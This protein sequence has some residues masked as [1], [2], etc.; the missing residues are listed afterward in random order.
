MSK[1]KN[2]GHL[3]L[4][5]PLVA[6]LAGHQDNERIT[7]RELK[8]RGQL[9]LLPL[10]ALFNIF[11]KSTKGFFFFYFFTLLTVRCRCVWYI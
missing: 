7:I 9:L 11:K 10:D 2:M 1:K 8:R 4:I 5:A 6:S 3:F